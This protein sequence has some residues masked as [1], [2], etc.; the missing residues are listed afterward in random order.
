MQYLTLHFN[1]SPCEFYKVEFGFF[2]AKHKNW[3]L[4]G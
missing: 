2:R 1:L 4:R 3:S